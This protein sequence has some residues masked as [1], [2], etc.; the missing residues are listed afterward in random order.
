MLHVTLRNKGHDL[1]RFHVFLIVMCFNII[2]LYNLYRLGYTQIHSP[3][4]ISRSEPSLEE[5]N[6]SFENIYVLQGSN[7]LRMLLHV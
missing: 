3:K 4:N 6:L 5:I 2:V 7:C 1:K